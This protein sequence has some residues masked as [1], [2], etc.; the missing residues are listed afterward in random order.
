MFV[1]FAGEKLGIVDRD[2]G[3]ITEVEVFISVLGARQLTYVEAVLTQ[4]KE[5]FIAACESALHYY[6]GVP[7]AIVTDNLK[8][9]V[10]KS[11][12]YEPTINETFA[13]FSGHYGTAASLLPTDKVVI[14]P[15][16][17]HHT[18]QTTGIMLNFADNRKLLPNMLH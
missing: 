16:N 12:R 11:S 2:S 6:G 9:A 15:R 7:A 8:A 13:D 14:L 3:K 18:V 1:D 5:G 4:Q 10:I 17:T